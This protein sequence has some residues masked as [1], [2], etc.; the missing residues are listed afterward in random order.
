MTG[1]G[2]IVELAGLPGAGKTAAATLLTE[3]CAS[4]TQS[5]IRRYLGYVRKLRVDKMFLLVSVIKFGRV[6]RRIHAGHDRNTVGPYILW[7]TG[8]VVRVA[9][10]SRAKVREYDSPA[11]SMLALLNELSVE[12][13]LA[14]F[15][16]RFTGKNVIL[17][18]GYVQRGLG[19]W[20]RSPVDVRTDV[21][22][23]YV[24]C[25][26]EQTK[27]VLLECSPSEAL[28]RAESRSRGVW[29]VTKWMPKTSGESAWIEQHYR[30]MAGALFGPSLADRVSLIRVDAM[31]SIDGV[32]DAVSAAVASLDARGRWVISART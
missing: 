14:G 19:V 24:S 11:E 2:N 20:L 22:D 28:R 16:A 6:F 25:I 3:K 10:A 12:R 29:A 30:D 17:D 32:A 7:A 8:L 26:P 18:E 21:W 1:L 15:E 31:L 4:T 5:S 9:K 23:A 13:W 27:C